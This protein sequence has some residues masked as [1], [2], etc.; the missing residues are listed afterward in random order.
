MGREVP[1]EYKALAFNTLKLHQEV[2]DFM[3]LRYRM[4]HEKGVEM[5]HSMRM[6]DIHHTPL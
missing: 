2:P 5:W 1:E 6:N 4:C 3:Q